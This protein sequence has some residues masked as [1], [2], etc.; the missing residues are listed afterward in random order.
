MEKNPQQEF[1]IH[2]AEPA[3]T[4]EMWAG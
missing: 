4:P 3:L 2:L 1:L